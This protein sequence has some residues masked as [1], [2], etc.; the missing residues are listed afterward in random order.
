HPRVEPLALFELGTG[1]VVVSLRHPRAGVQKERFGRR[2]VARCARGPLERRAYAEERAEGEAEASL[3]C[4][5]PR[6][7]VS[8]VR[9][10]RWRA[11]PEP[12]EEAPRRRKEKPPRAWRRSAS[13]DAEAQGPRS[14][15]LEERLPA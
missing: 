3:T 14:S 10:P 9:A 13:T 4:A 8:Q 2:L 11:L 15:S 12:K 6:S 1:P 5:H 7:R